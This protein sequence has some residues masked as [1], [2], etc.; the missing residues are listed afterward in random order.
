MATSD[1]T[2]DRRVE[3]DLDVR[4]DE[5]AREVFKLRRLERASEA[6]ARLLDRR[7]REFGKQQERTAR[8][9]E[10]E[11]RRTHFGKAPDP[12]PAHDRPER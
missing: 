5:H 10:A 8:R 2:D 1:M 12:R 3:H 7:L 11:Y 9:L 6:E 4:R